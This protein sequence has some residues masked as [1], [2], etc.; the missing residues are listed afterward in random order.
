MLGTAGEVQDKLVSDVLL[1]TSTHGYISVGRPA[2]TYIHQLCAYTEY[3]LEDFTKSD[4][5]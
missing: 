1:W 2:K 5:R 3:H 4:G